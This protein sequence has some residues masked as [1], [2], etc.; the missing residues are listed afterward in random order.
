MIEALIEKMISEG[1]VTQEEVDAMIA[2]AVSQQEPSE[3]EILK[4]QVADIWELLLF[5]GGE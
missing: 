2:E 3:S 1:K 4:Q 5:G